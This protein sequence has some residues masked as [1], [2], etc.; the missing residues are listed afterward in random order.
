MRR[1]VPE[2]R[3]LP[4]L[5][6][7]LLFLFLC[8][9]GSFAFSFSP[10][11]STITV[12]SGTPRR[13][14]NV[15]NDGATPVAIQISL[16][17]REIDL[18]GRETN[19]ETDEL[20]AYPSQFIL[21]GGERQEV[22]V[23]WVSGDG[24]NSERAYRITAEQIPLN[25]GD[26]PPGRARVRLN[27]RYVASLYVGPAGVSPD[28]VVASAQLLHGDSDRDSET[29]ASR[30]YAEVELENRGNAHK[31]L[32]LVRFSPAPASDSRPSGVVLPGER[33]I[34]RYPLADGSSFDERE[35]GSPLEVELSQ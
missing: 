22:F 33:L 21:R 27:V 20:I 2:C 32:S 13:S 25:L 29:E 11:V 23:E 15:R 7:V 26:E 10:M 17:T 1:S 5:T 14:Y 18:Y 24:P 3:I 6:T 30:F 9:A 34:I 4:A 31:A 28:L 8:P 35:D 16:A 12:E 19:R